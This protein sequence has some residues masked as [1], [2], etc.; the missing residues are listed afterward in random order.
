M[1]SHNGPPTSLTSHNTPLQ[2]SNLQ[3]R[4]EQDM[5]E[6]DIDG[7]R[8]ETSIRISQPQGIWQGGGVS[9]M[10]EVSFHARDGDKDQ[11]N[12]LFTWDLERGTRSYH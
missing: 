2:Q 12:G 8:T 11:D 9:A 5:A 7:R 1:R 4:P 3:I 6:R 10:D